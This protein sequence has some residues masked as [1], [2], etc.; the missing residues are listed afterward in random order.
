[1][2]LELS[3]AIPAILEANTPTECNFKPYAFHPHYLRLSVD[4]NVCRCCHLY[5]TV[6]QQSAFFFAKLLTG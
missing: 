6:C 2:T 4:V 3:S 5:Q 1:M